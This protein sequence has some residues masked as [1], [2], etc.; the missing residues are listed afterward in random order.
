MS[1]F[2]PVIKLF[3]TILGVAMLLFASANSL[4]VDRM[5]WFFSPGDKSVPGSFPKFGL[6]RGPEDESLE[7]MGECKKSINMSIYFKRG[8]LTELVRS[9]AYPSVNFH[10]PDGDVRV[11]IAALEV[12]ETG[13]ETWMPRID[14]LDKAL[15]EKLA[16]TPTLEIQLLGDEKVL[17]VYRPLTSKGRKST[18]LRVAKECF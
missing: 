15:F 12:N 16:V 6:S 9:N 11:F 14:Y 2:S 8:A 3:P 17:D 10:M 5:E 1:V 4:A 13:A 7:I 18:F